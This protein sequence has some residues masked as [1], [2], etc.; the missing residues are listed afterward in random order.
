MSR[1]PDGDPI[2]PE[3][4]DESASPSDVAPTTRARGGGAN[5]SPEGWTRTPDWERGADPLWRRLWWTWRDSVFRPVSFFRGLPARGGV[6]PPLGYALLVFAVSLFFVLYWSVLQ[7]ILATGRDPALQIAA[8]LVQFAFTLP[9]YVGVLFIV[10]GVLHVGFVLAGAGR[11][12]YEAT[13]RGLAYSTGPS[14]FAI[15]PFFG[16]LL[17]LVWGSVV[18]F[19]A[20]REVQRTTNGRTTLG[21]LIPLLAILVFFVL[22]GVLVA[23][24]VDPAELGPAL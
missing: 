24:V 15:L 10:A 21:F 13:F 19:I 8:A 9:L 17:A 4:G 12:G 3:A 20:L 18:T 23:L 22:L 16:S 6:G 2:E 14:A 11:Q 7:G 5:D 1:R